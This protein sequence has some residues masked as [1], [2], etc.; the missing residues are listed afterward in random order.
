MSER[1]DARSGPPILGID[2]G[3]TNSGVATWRGPGG[4]VEML[5]DADGEPLLPSAVGRDAEGGTW[6]V[7]RPALSLR[8]RH[9]GLV[10]TSVK[11]FIGRWWN[12]PAVARSR[13]ELPYALL[14]GG[15]EDAL[16]DVVID[17]GDERLSAPEA[18]AR[19]LARLRVTAAAAL[20]LPQEEV[21]RAVITVPAYFNVLQRR[22]TI[23]AGQLAGLEVVDILNEPTAAA[24]ASADE[25]LKPGDEKRLLVCDLGGGTYDVA[26]LE[27]T[28]D[29]EGY[30][31]TTVALDG[32]TRL[33]GDDVDSALARWL[34][35]EAG[36]RAGQ[37]YPAD[38][39]AA[40]ARLLR[41]AETAKIE[42]TQRE[43]VS[44]ELAGLRL[45]VN[46]AR[47][48]ECA[49]DVLSRVAAITRRVVEDVAGLAWGQIDEVIPVGGQTL[50]PAV[51]KV[52][53]DLWG[54]PPR[55][56]GS[57]Q[58]AVALGAGEYARILSRGRD[59]FHQNA[60]I[61]VIALPLGIRLDDEM[62]EPLVPANATAPYRSKPLAVTTTEDNQPRIRV[63]VLQGPR[64]ATR[65]GQC[66]A[67][68]SIDLEVP[69][70]PA[71]TPKFE[72]VFE[73]R[74]DGTL[75]VT[76]ADTRRDRRA[77]AT[78]NGYLVAWKGERLAAPAM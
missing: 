36:R 17:F 77:E 34:A 48:E 2:L 75:H 38:D 56:V 30:V 67:L 59:K 53:A 11:R 52:L 69:P 71:R 74:S 49:G 42:L 68:G 5:P 60:L 12:D 33:G 24:L 72:V 26:L 21:T 9:P 37:P 31:F 27:A 19:I 22:A 54:R 8:E 25:L 46:R 64:G 18:S 70:A 44:V 73:A 57:P 58:L 66:V 16:R 4:R 40:R 13:Q 35:E 55:S 14:P 63:D 10:A 6:L 20:R 65:A 7:G 61:N 50:M 41:A 1:N 29:E 76:V 45:A 3:T 78:L 39:P 32:D 15:G 23:L 51:R 47:L 28:R 62:F 43:E